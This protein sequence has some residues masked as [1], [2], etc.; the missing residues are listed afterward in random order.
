MSQCLTDSCLMGEG[1]YT[2]LGMWR[3]QGKGEQ[4]GQWSSMLVPAY[5]EV[6]LYNTAPLYPASSCP[7]VSSPMA[8]QPT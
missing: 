8:V 2:K 7:M 4:H 5:L 3:Y 6:V 1:G